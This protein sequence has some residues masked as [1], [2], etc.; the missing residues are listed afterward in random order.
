MGGVLSEGTEVAQLVPITRRTD[1]STVALAAYRQLDDLLG[2]LSVS[3]WSAPTAC[4]GWSVSDMVGHLIGAA[5]GNASLLEFTRQQMSGFRHRR[6][7][8]G[9]PLDAV[10]ARQIADH[11]GLPDSERAETLRAVV[12]DAVRG[13]MRL[14]AWAG[15]VRVP[16]SSDGSAAVGTPSTVSLAR[17]LDVVYTRDVWMHT[18]DI[19]EA[20]G[21]DLAMAAAV[22][23]RIVQDVV[24]DWVR[25]HRQP[26]DLALAGPAGG[27]YRSGSGADVIELDAIELCRIL[28]G[29]TP[30]DG[31]LNVKVLF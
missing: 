4:P 12:P 13:R 7:F 26:V 1:A 2:S 19:A 6:D 28:S 27:R 14:S 18:I 15:A 16:I 11:A 25:R 31:L 30:G 9:N 20:V 29:R 22:N 10:N 8:G 21:A 3:D 5:R 24:I 17:L 23:A